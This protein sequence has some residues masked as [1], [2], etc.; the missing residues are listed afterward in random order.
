MTDLSTPT[1]TASFSLKTYLSILRRQRRL[2]IVVIVVM[3]FLAM[4][5][6]LLQDPV[7][8][9]TSQ[10]RISSLDSEGVFSTDPVVGKTTN[11]RAIELLT[12]IEVISSA[13]LKARVLADSGVGADDFEGPMVTQRG[14]SEVVEI[15]VVADSPDIASDIANLY[16]DEYVE[17][18]RE[19]S[20]DT[21]TAKADELRGQSAAAN[22]ELQL[23]TQRLANEELPANEI[24]NL[25]LRQT[26]LSQ[27]VLD[28]DRRAD[29]LAVNA[30]LRGAATE[31]HQFAGL[32]LAPIRP[33]SLSAA[34]IGFVLGI[35]LGLALAVVF[36][37]IQD[38]VGSAEELGAIRQGVPVLATVPHAN[39]NGPAGSAG[40]SSAKE[41]F[42]YLRTGVR[43]FGL[44]S[45]LRSLVVTSAIGAEGKT[46]TAIGLAIAMADAGDR[47][48]LVDGDLR[49]PSLHEH[50]GIPNEVG[51]SSI[52]VGDASFENAVHFVRDNLA[53]VP[54]GPPVQ[55]PPQLLGTE[56]FK[57]VLDAMVKQSDFMILDSTP[58]LPVADA[59]IAGQHVDGAVVVG[60]IGQVRRR[61]VREL[62]GRFQEAEIPLIGLIANDAVKAVDYG[63]YDT[64]YQVS[65]EPAGTPS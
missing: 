45:N 52:L 29:E 55:D 59:L 37:T 41:A 64:E 47:V 4:L 15:N 44:N 14:F 13:S 7:Y 57:R 25:Q 24:S 60:R 38:R 12:E 11:D 63:Y 61:A 22:T 40:S 18:R 3:T 19:R 48:V 33:S 34:A 49:R 43:V 50:F 9:A 30:S 8:S 36:D 16:A 42:R 21:L 62:F 1:S 26:T 5:P 51:L 65:A 2:I 35:L 53:V 58:V 6:P 20:V 54:A 17:D 46:S 56:R 31:V 27:Q 23:L 32:D 28:F 10:V 39:M